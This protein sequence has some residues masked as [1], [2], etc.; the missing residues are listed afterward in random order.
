MASPIPGLLLWRESVGNSSV[1]TDP[2]GQ[3]VRVRAG[4]AGGGRVGGSR[5]PRVAGPR[6]VE[7]ELGI[8]HQLQ[9]QLPGLPVFPTSSSLSQMP[10]HLSSADPSPRFAGRGRFFSSKRQSERS[11]Q[12]FHRE[13]RLRRAGS[14]QQDPRGVR[15]GP[16]PAPRERR[17]RRYVGGRPRPPASTEGAGTWGAVPGPPR[18]PKAHQWT[19]S[20]CRL[21][22]GSWPCMSPCTCAI[23]SAR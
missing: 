18:A 9:L 8:Q 11:E 22:F 12:V 1:R 23:I 14:P 16:S 10:L 15:G 5:G 4:P 6:L 3:R 7:L 17:R 19:D 2:E 13:A 21:L 20:E